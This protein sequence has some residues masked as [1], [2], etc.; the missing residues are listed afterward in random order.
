MDDDD[1][2]PESHGNTQP[3]QRGNQNRYLDN[4][5][6]SM[7]MEADMGG[8]TERNP[9]SARNGGDRR[10]QNSKRGAP[11]NEDDD[12]RDPKEVKLNFKKRSQNRK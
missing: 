3:Q 2:S 10:L 5:E 6:D 11:R 12:Y 7:D 8:I 1:Y 9:M 4:E